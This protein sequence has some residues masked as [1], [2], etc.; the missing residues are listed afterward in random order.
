[1]NKQCLYIKEK[2]KKGYAEAYDGD[3]IYINRPWQKRGVVQREGIQTIK[4]NC[5]DIG[6]VVMQKV[7]LERNKNDA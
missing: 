2:T 5:N 1:M 4:A 3:G 7:L 6:V